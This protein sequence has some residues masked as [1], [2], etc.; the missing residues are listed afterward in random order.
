MIRLNELEEKIMDALWQL[1]SAFPKDVM[2]K[3]DDPEL[4]YNTVLSAIRKLEKDGLVG[5]EVFGKFH[6]Y[7]PITQK[8]EYGKSLFNKLYHDILQ[9]SKMDLLSYFM[10]EEKVNVK[11]LEKLLEKIKNNQK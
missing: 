9:G 7:Y 3:I 10:K 2:A 11:E 4:P 6:E 8:E 5:H 1:G